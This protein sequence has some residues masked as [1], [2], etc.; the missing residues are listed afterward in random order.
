MKIDD[1]VK[2]LLKIVD[3]LKKTYPPKKFTLDGRLVGDLGETLV[4]QFYDVIL[5]EKIKA[6]YD[7]ETSD[8]KNVQIKATM[9]ESLT[10]PA[11]FV[12]DFYIGIKIKED[13]TFD[14]IYNG[15]GKL[16][17]QLIK[18]KNKPSNNLHNIPINKLRE[19]N[20]KVEQSKKIERRY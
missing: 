1:A 2:S 16:I 20:K 13:G 5:H 11:D 14:E 6:K 17:H 12:P 19:L 8:G 15:P 10:Y 3:D 4:G 18:D 7:G 9:Q